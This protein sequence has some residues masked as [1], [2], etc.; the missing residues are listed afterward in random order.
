MSTLPDNVTATAAERPLV[1]PPK[2]AGKVA[3]GEG[4][5]L[6]Q[7]RLGMASGLF[8]A[9]EAKHAPS[10]AHSFR[11]AMNGSAWLLSRKVAEEEL[12]KLEMAFL[13]HDLGKIGVPDHILSKPGRLSRDE[14]LLVEHHRQN[15]INI[16]L[17]C[18]APRAV[19]E[20]IH[21]S[22]A[23]FD[24]SKKGFDVTGG[25]IP[26]GARILAIVD[27]FD[28]MTTDQVYRPA[29]SQ[30]LA[31]AELFACAGT[32]F[33]PELVGHFAEWL[34]KDATRV[35]ERVGQ[36]WLSHL[37][38]NLADQY[39]GFQSRRMS[40]GDSPAEA[41][42]YAKAVE[43]MRD[44]VIF[45]DSTLRILAWNRAAEQITGV[46]GQAV[47]RM[48]W[49]AGLLD[50]HSERGVRLSPADDQV[51]KAVERKIPC[52][53]R[54][55]LRGRR[56]TPL[57]V[58]ARIDPVVSGDGTVHGVTIVIEDV[59]ARME[60]EERMQSLQR[61]ATRDPLTGVLNREEFAR[62]HEETLA[63]HL[64]RR[65]PCALVICDLDYFKKVNDTYGHQAGDEALIAFARILE[66]R[67]RTDDIVARYGGEEFLLLCPNC[68]LA[69]AARMAE[70]VRVALERTSLPCLGNKSLTSSF[71]VTELQ[72]GDTAETMLRRAD[73][74]LLQAKEI[75]RN[76]VVRIGA[77]LHETPSAPR[78]RGPLEW[79]LGTSAPETVVARTLVTPVPAEMILEKLRGFA[80]D[81]AAEVLRFD[82]QGASLKLTSASQG[83]D[84]RMDD[85]PIPF[86]IELE[87]LPADASERIAKTRLK[88]GVFPLRSRDRRARN[89]V[90][91]A[92]QIMNS[93][94]SYLVAHEEASD[95][96]VV[97]QDEAD[98]GLLGRAGSFFR[99][100]FARPTDDR[101]GGR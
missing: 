81:H 31:T 50:L 59:S 57:T 16:L 65:V 14:L 51:R 33:D 24:G 5:R 53:T 99:K 74:A 9:L 23:Y 28:S 68:D 70:E 79:L 88:V 73:R 101:Y 75:G 13:L 64:A 91:R 66:Q 35:L 98:E 58:D 6:V 77:G 36:R 43:G 3:E 93:V 83:F 86:R 72:Y 62:T 38:Q 60:I 100:S 40:S 25:A 26:F 49:T 55:I 22:S 48:E 56:A 18:R 71:G 37:G 94:K 11:V 54:W 4:L 29:M 12:L 90:E 87:F 34:Q 82:A 8:S 45:V 1:A 80:S 44:G 27:A 52:T 89:V 47:W 46:P 78:Q 20:T 96:S 67:R 7:S 10:A 32:Q 85:R 2:P 17:G 63:D 30:E 97:G 19:L 76:V 41:I 92:R 84:R 69:G 42:F 39:W 21:F 95:A 61:R 15:A